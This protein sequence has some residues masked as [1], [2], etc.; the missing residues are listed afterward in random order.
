[1]HFLWPQKV[2]THIDSIKVRLAQLTVRSLQEIDFYPGRPGSNHTI[3][4]IFFF[5]FFFSAMLHSFVTTFV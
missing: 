2:R 5:F 1:M 3:G 4:G